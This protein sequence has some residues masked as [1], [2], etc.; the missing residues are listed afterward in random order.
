MNAWN[1]DDLAQLAERELQLGSQSQYFHDGR[2]VIVKSND[3]HAQLAV[4]VSA[5]PSNF[6]V[7]PHVHP[8]DE[9]ALVL[10][11]SGWA[12][13]ED[14]RL[15]IQV[16]SLLHTPGGASHGTA[17]DERGPMVVLWMYAPPDSAL[18]WLPRARTGEAQAWRP[19]SD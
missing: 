2:I 17:S 1:I 14:S 10:R 8:A 15:D 3:K 11:G 6:E 5:L 9:V 12:S 18:R 13:L 19:H 4:G 16:G 7:P